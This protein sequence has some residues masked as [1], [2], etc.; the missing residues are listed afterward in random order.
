MSDS[1][2]FLM[3]YEPTILSFD[4]N[5]TMLAKSFS[6]DAKGITQIWYSSLC[7]GSIATWE[8]LKT[9]Q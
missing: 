3:N 5:T 6:M 7:L 4:G 1:K 9:N 2:Q 8:Q